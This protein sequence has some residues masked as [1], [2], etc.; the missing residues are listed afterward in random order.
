MAFNLCSKDGAIK[1]AIPLTDG[2]MYYNSIGG[3]CYVGLSALLDQGISIEVGDYGDYEGQRFW[4]VAQYTPRQEGGRHWRYNVQLYGAQSIIQGALMLN[5]LGSPLFALTAPAVEHIR[6]VVDNINRWLGRSEWRI[7]EVVTTDSITIDYSSGVYCN[8]AMAKIAEQTHH[9]WW[10]EGTTLHLGKCLRGEP[11]RLRYQQGLRNIEAATASNVKFFS[12]LYPI[13]SSRNIDVDRYGDTRLHLPNG[14]RYIERNTEHGIV[15]HYEGDAFADIYPKRIGTLSS[16]RSH[17]MRSSQGKSY[18]IYYVKD[19]A[20][21]FD[22]NKYSIGGLVKHLVF[23]TGD[24]AG[25]DFECNYDS[26]TGEFELITQYPYNDDTQLPN[27]TLAPKQGDTYVLYNLRM[28]DEYYPL[29]EQELA[30]AVAKY[31]DEHCIDHSLYKAATDYIYWADHQII[32]Q[33]G[34]RVRLYS[35]EL[36]GQGGYR[37]TRITQV[38]VKMSRPTD[39]DIEMSDV[40]SR[41]TQRKMQDDIK[42]LYHE[43]RAA[44]STLPNII[45]S[46]EG[47]PPTDNNLYSARAVSRRYLSKELPDVAQ[48]HIQFN[49]G[50]ELGSYKPGLS[51]TGGVLDRQGNAELRSLRLWDRLEVPELRY[52]RV[53]IYTGI[54]WD[55]FGGGIIERCESTSETTGDLYLKLEQGEIG[56]IAEGD[57]CMGIWHDDR[58]GNH[59]S[60]TDDRRGNFSFAGFKTVYFRIDTIPAQDPR[61]KDNSDRHYCRY[62]LREDAPLIHPYS[63]MHFAARG[64]IQDK[65]RQAFVYTTTEYSLQLAGVDSWIFR[66]EHYKHIQGNLQGFSLSGKRFDGYGGILKDV[67]IY[68]TIEQF[69]NAPLRIEYITT[70]GQELLEEESTTIIPTLYQ[71]YN[72]I[73]ES[74]QWTMHKEGTN[75]KVLQPQEMHISYDDLLQDRST[76]LYTLSATCKQGRAQQT[77]AIRRLRNGQDPKLF[78]VEIEQGSQFYRS[79]QSFIARLRA[80][81][82]QGDRDITETLHPSQIVWT[83]QSQGDDKAWAVAHQSASTTIDITTDDMAGDTTIIATLYDEHGRIAAAKRLSIN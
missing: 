61:G 15:E 63:S 42:S 35:D 20:L 68:G 56:G 46:W 53:S 71:G 37:D 80:Y 29:A 34:Q 54:R 74:I 75:P 40:L 66:E 67:H 60:T 65:S 1:L 8:E 26:I 23:Q 83:R 14:Q 2:C 3:D 69:D 78:V 72:A 12:R 51:G 39:A 13:G 24:L 49:D 18:S 45:R 21:P 58:G 43:V 48:G 7:G 79:E 28:P 36:F 6:L 5:A 82:L 52:N 47:T 16:V 62:V 9:E 41:T 81:L 22:P 70:H 25:L 11:I 38:A 73:T 64:N 57:L 77:I 32:P 50:I 27:E 76:T 4:A 33:I 19:D 10:A 30:T 17:E 59:S 55:T 44:Q 31:M